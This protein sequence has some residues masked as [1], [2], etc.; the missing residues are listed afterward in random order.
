MDEYGICIFRTVF[1]EIGGQLFNNGDVVCLGTSI[2][3][4]PAVNLTV[5]KRTF[6]AQIRKSNGLIINGMKMGKIVHKSFAKSGCQFRCSFKFFWFL[7]AQDNPFDALHDIERR[8]DYRSIITVG[9]WFWSGGIHRVKSRENTEFPLHVMSG[10]NLAALGRTSQDHLLGVTL[11]KIGQVGESAGKLVYVC[12]NAHVRD[13]LCKPVLQ[14]ISVKFFAL[15]YR[16]RLI[17]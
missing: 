16:A 2:T 10:F 9:K 12:N 11:D 8:T 6:P 5:R 17:Q 3:V 1:L 15:S 13:R 14:G 4:Y 7:A